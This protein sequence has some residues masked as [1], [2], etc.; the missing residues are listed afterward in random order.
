MRSLQNF[1]NLRTDKSALWEIQN[2]A[3]AVFEALP[4]EHKFMFNSFVKE[5]Q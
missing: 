4:E 2:L 5:Q 3:H 1:L